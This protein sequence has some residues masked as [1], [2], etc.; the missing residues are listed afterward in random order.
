MPLLHAYEDGELGGSAWSPG[1][2]LFGAGL[3]SHV[4]LKGYK[5]A[6][7]FLQAVPHAGAEARKPGGAGGWAEPGPAAGAEA[8][9]GNPG[10][11]GI[12]LWQHFG[13][14]PGPR[15]KFLGVENI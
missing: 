9:E 1:G 13:C 10:L 2:G 4:P 14:S 11:R 8:A 12:S 3:G 15:A 5:R 7:L 6:D